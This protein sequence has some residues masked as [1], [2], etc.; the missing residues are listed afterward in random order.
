MDN[1]KRKINIARIIWVSGIFI[2][3]IIILLLVM[4]YK[5]NYQYLTKNYL[6]FYECTDGVCVTRIK[7]KEKLLFSTY[8]CGYEEC[9]EYKKNISDNYVLLDENNKHLLYDYKN[10][11]IITDAYE[12]YE[13]IDNEY[14]ITKK[15]NK[16]GI[17][18]LTQEEIIKPI[19]DEIGIHYNGYLSGYNMTSIIAK[20]NNLYGIISYKDGK[21]IEEFKYKEQDLSKVTNE[22]QKE[23]S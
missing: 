13:F 19:Y 5:I 14:I 12:D 21:I 15:S 16:Y 11:K 9:P 4:N 1:K 23:N 8:D 3:L 10:N 20:K 2:I 18:K 22:I 6:Y 17:I 7:D